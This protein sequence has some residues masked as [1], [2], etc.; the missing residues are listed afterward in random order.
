MRAIASIQ[1]RGL[2]ERRLKSIS[3][4]LNWA[5]C[6]LG[7]AGFLICDSSQVLTWAMIALPLVGVLLVANLKPYYRFGGP[8]NSPLPDLSLVLIVPGLF[9]MLEALQSIAPIGWHG[10]LSVTV[11]GVSFWSA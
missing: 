8:R 4:V 5:V 3:R 9:L 11:L 10:A 1:K 2:S 6:G 7:I